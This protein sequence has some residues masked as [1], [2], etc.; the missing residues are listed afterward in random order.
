[1]KHGSAIILIVLIYLFG[2]DKDRKEK[3]ALVPDTEGIS[4]ELKMSR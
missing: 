1:M 4:V 3:C 2:C